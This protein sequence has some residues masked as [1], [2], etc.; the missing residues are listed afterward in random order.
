MPEAAPAPFNVINPVRKDYVENSLR[1]GVD[2]NRRLPDAAICASS[3]EVEVAM[4]A[5]NS[6]LTSPKEVRLSFSEGVIAKLSGVELKDTAG[7]VISAG[8]RSYS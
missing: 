8:S 6:E 4:P 5:E 7:K 2:H 1:F 3:S